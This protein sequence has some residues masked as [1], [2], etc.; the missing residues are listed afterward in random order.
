MVEIARNETKKITQKI[1]S[2]H[3][4]LAGAILSVGLALLAIFALA[5][6]AE[7]STLS[8]GSQHVLIFLAGLGFGTTTLEIIRQKGKEK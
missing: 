1:S 8:H 3:L 4:L 7:T 6:W 2:Q 5:G